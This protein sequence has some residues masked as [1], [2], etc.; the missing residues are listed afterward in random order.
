MKI[1]HVI[2]LAL[3]LTAAAAVAACTPQ[4]A[5]M[6]MEEWDLVWI[7]DSSGWDVAEVYAALI[8]EDTGITVN[9]HDNWI[10]GLPAATVL[11]ALQG[12]PTHSYTL[13]HLAD[14]LREAE[15]IVFY[16][17]PVGSWEEDNP[18]DWVCTTHT[19][20]Y[21]NNCEME[22]FD[23]YIAD[24]EAIYALIFELRDGQPTIVRAFD[25]YNPRVSNF[26]AEGCYE[27]CTA[28]WDNYNAA[29]HQ[30]AASYNIPVAAVFEAWNGAGWTQDPVALGYTKDGEHPSELGAV[31]IAEA[32]VATGYEPVVP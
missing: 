25:A 8:E 21:V 11:H 23:T 30:A 16:G 9:V 31:V 28:C 1:T 17:N 27:A 29:I 2:H 10:G 24:L 22:T 4:P 32:L 3:V 26:Q 7:S 20:N 12:T 14:E 18:A 15:I 6:E 13:E 19:G 5:L